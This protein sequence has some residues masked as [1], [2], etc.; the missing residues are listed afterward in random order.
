MPFPEQK[1]R[2]FT[3]ENIERLKPDQ[4]GRFGIYKEGQ[5]IYIG[6][7][8]IRTRLLELVG[9]ANPCIVRE[10][11]THWLNWRTPNEEFEYRRLLMEFSPICNMKAP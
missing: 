2:E 8:D 5:W 7:G 11:P 10:K 9:G 6:H 3:K 1:P 4:F